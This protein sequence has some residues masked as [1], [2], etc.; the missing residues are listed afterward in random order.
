MQPV[1]PP[2]VVIEDFD[3]QNKHLIAPLKQS[4][5]YFEKI[6]EPEDEASVS[7]TVCML[8]S[9]ADICRIAIAAGSSGLIMVN[10][11]LLSCLRQVITQTDS[12]HS[13]CVLIAHKAMPILIC[14]L[15]TASHIFSIMKRK[16]SVV[17][18]L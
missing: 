1:L 5:L 2:T 7:S 14:F 11:L 17:Q 12:S 16:Y 4:V 18:C 3:W 9:A 13:P 15:D 6:G 10:T 8:L